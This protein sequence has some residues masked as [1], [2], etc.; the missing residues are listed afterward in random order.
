M[1]RLFICRSGSIE[2]PYL[3]KT[4]SESCISRSLIDR[5]QFLLFGEEILE[6]L[7]CDLKI[8]VGYV[9]AGPTLASLPG[10]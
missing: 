4:V 9:I 2:L 3:P 5:I 6:Q 10:E 1:N 8:A 7:R